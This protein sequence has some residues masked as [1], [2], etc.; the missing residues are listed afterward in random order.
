[1][2]KHP[3][4][5]PTGQISYRPLTEAERIIRRAAIN[6]G[7]SINEMIDQAV[8]NSKL[9]KEAADSKVPDELAKAAAVIAKHTGK[10]V[11]EI[12]QKRGRGRPKKNPA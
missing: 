5:E 9:L 3:K 4:S 8:L 11:G 6:T 1:M 2:S 12:L 10:E 7:Q